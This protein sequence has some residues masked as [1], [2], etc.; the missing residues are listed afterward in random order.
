M[1]TIGFISLCL[2]GALLQACTES[3]STLDGDA[4]EST[5]G[6]AGE[7]ENGGPE[8][9]PASTVNAKIAT[10]VVPGGEIVFV[11]EGLTE[12][13]GGIAFWE[14][15]DTDLSSLLDD[16]NATALEVFLALAPE[17]TPVPRR[18]VEH[19]A[20]VS[21]RVAGIAAEPRHLAAPP[22]LFGALAVTNEGLNDGNSDAN[23]DCWAWAG[24]SNPYA[25][26]YGYQGFDYLEFQANFNSQYSQIASGAH[27][28]GGLQQR[29]S[30]VPGVGGPTA[31]GHERAMAFCLS[32][33]VKLSSH[34][35]LS[36]SCQANQGR[37]MV[38][39]ERTTDAAYNDWVAADSILLE[40]FGHGGRFRSNYTNSGGGARK[41]RLVLE[42][43]TLIAEGGSNN[44]LCADELAI[45]WRSKLDTNAPG[46]V[47]L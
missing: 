45:T 36:E 7:L 35:S 17:G 13:G 33:A 23:R 14:L 20:E 1:K 18:L 12:P 19:H 37:V 47:T 3:P 5:L 26:N 6:E 40:G 9:A 25:S 42:W 10:L 46:D 31:A 24:T 21:R 29:Q 15:G 43:Q 39:V 11:D 22:R 38:H 28:S 16:S 27:V 4:A 34:E 30:N 41:Y 44:L 32:K 8:A 2:A